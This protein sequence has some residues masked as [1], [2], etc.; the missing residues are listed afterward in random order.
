[1]T[2]TDTSFLTPGYSGDFPF[3]ALTEVDPRRIRIWFG[4]KKKRELVKC[5]SSKGLVFFSLS[6]DDAIHPP[7]ETL[8]DDEQHSELFKWLY[9]KPYLKITLHTCT[10]FFQKDPSWMESIRS[11]CLCLKAFFASIIWRMK[12]PIWQVFVVLKPPLSLSLPPFFTAI[13]YS[14]TN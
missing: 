9:L 6:K 11:H 2:I 4:Q 14:S 3:T 5:F 7:K 12:N 8:G 10:F 1:M 13:N